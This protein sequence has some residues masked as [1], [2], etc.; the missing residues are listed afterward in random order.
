M[1]L[2]IE[3]ET[4]KPSSSDPALA[5]YQ[6]A[7]SQYQS[8]VGDP[9]A[10]LDEALRL[11]PDF[12]LGH[13]FRALLLMTLGEQRFA[14]EARRSVSEATARLTG[15]SRR[16]RGLCAAARALTDGEWDRACTILDQVIVDHPHD[17][18]A[19]QTAHLM[20]FYR[21]DSLNLR[22]RIARVLPEWSESVPGYSYVLGMYAFGLEECHQYD[23]AEDAAR[24][25]LAIEPKDGWAV[26]AAAHVMEMQGR[27]DEGIAWLTSREADWAPDNAFASHNYWHLALFQLDTA[28]WD[29]ALALYDRRIHG[30]AEP[31]LALQL[32]D[33]TSLLWRF[34]LEGVDVGDRAMRLADN[35]AT[36]LER[37]RGFYVFNDAHATMAFAMAGRDDAAA[38]LAADV[39][40]TI[41]NGGDT[42]RGM[43]R[44]VGRPICRAIRAFGDERYEDALAELEPVRD[45][46][47]RFGGSHAQRDV[48]SLT[49]IEAAI[50][51]G[52]AALAR[53]YI[54]ERLASKPASAWGRRLCDR[55]GMGRVS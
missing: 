30:D 11:A 22:N 23:E 10:T 8:Y 42:N 18:L 25:A 41:V 39:D 43:A 45:I 54:N 19:I 4:R 29:D 17:M 37:E 33:A 27:I 2:Q 50:R 31:D 7:L 9:I 35:W 53:H 32:V 51:S 40:W 28:R 16:E 46:S 3:P 48:L 49:L 34:Y 1:N 5:L 36:R 20:D 6:R 26:H 13:T 12:L 21:G 14:E 24:R 15:A 47:H 44:D 52:R 38:Q 55:I